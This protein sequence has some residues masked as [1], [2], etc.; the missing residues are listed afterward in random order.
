MSVDVGGR[1]GQFTATKLCQAKLSQSVWEGLLELFT[2]TG[3][4][5]EFGGRLEPLAEGF[6]W[7]S[8]GFGEQASKKAMIPERAKRRHLLFI[9]LRFYS[10]YLI[11]SRDSSARGDSHN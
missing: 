1:A 2:F 3:T 5:Q 7:V 9:V 8:G 11:E 4:T 10:E 6:V